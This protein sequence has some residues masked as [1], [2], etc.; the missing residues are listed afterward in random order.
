MNFK[1]MADQVL[2]DLTKSKAQAER[3]LTLEIIELLREISSRRLHLKR[4][5]SSLHEY[6]VK[7]LK[8]DDGQAHRRIKALNLVTQVPEA[9]ESIQS[10]A[11]TLTAA[12]Q[13]QNFFEREAKK[14]KAYT[15][16]AKLELLGQLE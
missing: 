4:S 6:C 8:Y 15:R 1:N 10:G 11:L 14:D 16:E 12:S 3:N 13:V 2:W 7:V 9:I 5:Y